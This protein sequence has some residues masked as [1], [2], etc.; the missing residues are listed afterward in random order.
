MGILFDLK[1]LTFHGL[2]AELYRR[3]GNYAKAEPPLFKALEIQRNPLGENHPDYANSLKFLVYLRYMVASLKTNSLRTIPMI[4][5][6]TH[7]R[8]LFFYHD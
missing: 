6:L 5:A 4:S 3:I 1:T 2:L 7:R 8:K